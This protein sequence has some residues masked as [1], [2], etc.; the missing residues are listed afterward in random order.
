[1]LCK[2][3]I[4]ATSARVKCVAMK[5]NTTKEEDI[6]GGLG[7]NKTARILCFAH[8]NK[9]D[10]IEKYQV[11]NNPC[12]IS[13]SS[14]NQPPNYC[15]DEPLVDFK[16]DPDLYVLLEECP[17]VFLPNG[18]LSD[19]LEN[20]ENADGLEGNEHPKEG[21]EFS[22]PVLDYEINGDS[23]QD[24]KRADEQGFIDPE[25][26]IL[27]NQER[28]IQVFRSLKKLV[29]TSTMFLFKHLPS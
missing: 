19:S 2:K 24:E 4:F 7:N 22:N 9:S 11:N 18:L 10:L 15:F 16:L 14:I 28:T 6:Q 20:Y 21:M 5:L 1:M 26:K 17:P 3:N 13:S 27:I 29:V 8:T 25:T 12:E 23:K